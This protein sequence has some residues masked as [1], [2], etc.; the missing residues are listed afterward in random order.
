[1]CD[2]DAVQLCERC[3]EEILDLN[4][5]T[6]PAW[7]SFLAARCARQ[8]NPAPGPSHTAAHL[9]ACLAVCPSSL[10]FG[11]APVCS[12]ECYVGDRVMARA[13]KKDDVPSD[14]GAAGVA[15]PGPR[16]HQ[17]AHSVR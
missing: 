8:Q 4:S 3:Q 1:M 13:T 14:Q 10:Q 2:A 9:T 17:A 6:Q 11:T 7:V 12:G 16:M 15:G 5:C